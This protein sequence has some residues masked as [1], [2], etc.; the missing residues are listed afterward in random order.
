MIRLIIHHT[1]MDYRRTSH[2]YELERYRWRRDSKIHR[3][4]STCRSLSTPLRTKLSASFRICKMGGLYLAKQCLETD[5]QSFAFQRSY[6]TWWTEK[7][8]Q[9]G[10]FPRNLELF[11]LKVQIQLCTREWHDHRWTACHISRLL[12]LPNVHSFKT[13]P[14]WDQNLDSR[15]QF[16]ILL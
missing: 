11:R 2:E 7:E 5:L 14:I 15:R 9:A 12:R 16:F 1:N 4:S 6:Y 8:W 10:P 13:R 3:R